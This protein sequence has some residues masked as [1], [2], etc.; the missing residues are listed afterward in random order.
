M[1][2]SKILNYW[3]IIKQISFKEQKKLTD[4]TN[5]GIFWNVLDPLLYMIIVSTYYEKIIIHDIP[6]FPL[7]VFVGIIMFN[8]YKVATLGA[9]KS[10]INNKRLLIKTKVP[11]HV[12]IIQKVVVAFRDML[13]GSIALLPIMFFFKVPLRPRVFVVLPVLVLV[14]IIVYSLG[15]I[16]AIM[17]VY[18]GDIEYLYQIFLTIL[19]FTSGVFIPLDH[20]PDKLQR[21]MEYNPIFLSVYISRN[22]IIY[23]LPSH[24]T[25]WV[26]LL[27]WS[28][29]LI[30]VSH[31]IYNDNI[32]N[33]VNKL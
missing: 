2:K 14:T 33:C 22:A 3:F 8:Y 28:V 17:C 1:D 30:L 15:K 29:A 11:V 9:M 12:F 26:K 27:I 5:L 24:W 19:I 25:A 7:F 21:I 32:D 20:L 31:K 16:L 4:E 6:Y 13:Y 18:F 10:L 23:D